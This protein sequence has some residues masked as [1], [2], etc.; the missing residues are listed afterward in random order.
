MCNMVVLYIGLPFGVHF[1][2]YGT[3]QRTTHILIL[4]GVS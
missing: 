2:K 4:V 3:L 1:K